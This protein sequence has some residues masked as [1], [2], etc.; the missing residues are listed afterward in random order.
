M[1]IAVIGG[2]AA[3]LV[4]AWLL[5][6]V[7]QV[8]LYEA[9]PH[10]GGHA[11]TVHVE[12]DGAS[13]PVET[14]FRYFFPSSYPRL[15]GLMA[16]HGLQV[17][18][19]ENRIGIHRPRTGRQLMLPPSGLREW[20]SLFSS[21]RDVLDLRL[22]HQFMTGG[23]RVIA[24]RDWS[25]SLSEYL[26]REGF[27]DGF[28]ERLLYPLISAS[29]GAPLEIMPDFPAYSVVKVMRLTGSKAIHL[30]LHG[31]IETYVK[32][33]VGALDRTEL[34]VG[35]AVRR[36]ARDGEQWVVDGV[37]G[38]QRFDRVVLATPAW[39][40]RR[41]LDPAA[42][43]LHHWR[44]ALGRFTSF[45]AR[46]RIHTDPSWM[47]EE[48]RHWA[49]LN[50]THEPERAWMTEW[51]GRRH[52]V[53]AFRTWEPLG[54]RKV[55]RPQAAVDFRHL[56]LTPAN[57]GYQARLAELQGRCGLHVAGMY[58]VD[59]DNHESSVRSAWEVGERL[60]PEGA[61]LASWRRAT[62][63]GR[64]PAIGPA[65]PDRPAVAAHGGS[66]R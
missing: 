18:E 52:G 4:S 27:P 31:G 40:A 25:C 5:Q 62:E 32:A 17:Y 61:N 56:V 38:R 13:V 2:G 16:L 11:H 47:P 36:I 50:H 6:D 8:T 51:A 43:E 30:G 39:V 63:L 54:G 46:I 22:L 57:L 33:L 15:M 55:A 19:S 60:A 14:G 7:H 65:V 45:E 29:W 10:L 53:N 64:Q 34:R 21:P 9:A 23:E 35:V 42:A 48:R 26:Q 58:V 66:R 3:G 12:K 28:G 41:L 20:T 49:D 1:K 37:R 44:E 24:S 59:V